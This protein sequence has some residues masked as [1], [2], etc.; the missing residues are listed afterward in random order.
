MQ[1]SLRKSHFPNHKFPSII[2]KDAG[3]S[4]TLLTHTGGIT[5]WKAHGLR[6]ES[7][8]QRTD[9]LLPRQP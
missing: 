4:E 8:T 9:E 2:L 7:G 6:V 3:V 5:G 1:S